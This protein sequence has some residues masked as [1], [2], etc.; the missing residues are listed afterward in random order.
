MCVMRQEILG[1]E[2]DREEDFYTILDEGHDA[3][4][5]WG[6]S[7]ECSVQDRALYGGIPEDCPLQ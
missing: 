7:Y 4:L 3:M 1:V 5:C 6:P 2:L